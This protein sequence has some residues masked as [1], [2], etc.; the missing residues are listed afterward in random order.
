M[1][2]FYIHDYETFGK[3]PSMDRP[4]QFAG[5]RTDTDFN[6]VEEPLVIYCILADDYLPDPEAV[7]IT[8]ITPQNTRKKGVNEAE[9]AR[10]IHKAFSV[11]GTCIIGYNNI[12]FD[13][14][15]SRNIFYRNFYDPYS[16]SW[17]NNNSRWD[18]LEVI[19]ACYAL[20]P[21]GIS[22]P[23][24]ENGAVSFRL[25]HLTSA[26]GI[27]HAQSHNAMSDVYATISM[28]KKVKKMQ[29][30][31]FDFLLRYRTKQ[32]INTLIDIDNMTPLVY[33]SSIFGGARRNT[34]LVSPIAWHPI[35]KNA[36]VMCDLCADLRPLLRLN[37]DELREQMFSRYKSIGTNKLPI[38][39]N[40]VY[41]NK[42]PVL[43][44]IS[45]LQA[46][47]EIRLG[48]DLRSCMEN[49]K[50]LRQFKKLREKVIS[51]FSEK[52]TCTRSND[53]DTQLYDGFFS[54]ETA[55]QMKIIQQTKPDNLASLN[56]FFTDNRMKELLF[57]FRARNYP[58]TL[59]N[60]EKKRWVRHCQERLSAERSSQYLL[61]LKTLHKLYEGDKIKVGILRRLLEYYQDLV[62]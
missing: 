7:I 35:N 34:S 20:R 25:E 56:L 28:A 3:S 26:N 37:A 42:C 9:F 52:M 30:K 17:K 24:K 36:I 55:V 61:K 54:K 39:L 33:V 53:V 27:K 31:L 44:P 12:R 22:W 11:P 43:V 2:T 19:R 45:T 60:S 23:R 51:I 6:I 62:D 15:V 41:T 8:G 29:P 4:A 58:D 10:K 14:E 40:L 5:I 59:K 50:L 1:A 13:D 16:Y 46:E 57:R 47:N 49:L 18:L 48:I 32:K 38:P 21:S